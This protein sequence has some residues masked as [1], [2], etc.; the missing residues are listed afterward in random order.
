MKVGQHLGEL[1]EVGGG[2]LDAGHGGDGVPGLLEELGHGEGDGG[3]AGD[4]VVKE[5]RGGRGQRDLPAPLHQLVNVPC[6]R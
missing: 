6:N 2:E 4:V 5:R 1:P 3:E